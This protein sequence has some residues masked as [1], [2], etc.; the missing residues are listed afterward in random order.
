[1]KD[2]E[3]LNAVEKMIIKRYKDTKRTQVSTIAQVTGWWDCC[4]IYATFNNLF[5]NRLIL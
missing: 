2:I 3:H 5:I 1:M 4:E